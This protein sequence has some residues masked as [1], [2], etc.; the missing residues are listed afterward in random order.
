MWI[1]GGNFILFIGHLCR[2]DAY[3]VEL[4]WG[5]KENPQEGESIFHDAKCWRVIDRS[6]LLRLGIN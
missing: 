1:E 5:R 3:G 2:C 4:A 6:T